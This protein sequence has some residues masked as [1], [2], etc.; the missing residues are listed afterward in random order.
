MIRNTDP[1]DEFYDRKADEYED[2][3][4]FEKKAQEKEVYE[5]DYYG[6]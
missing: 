1:E 6:W 2:P 3:V 5:E 4:D